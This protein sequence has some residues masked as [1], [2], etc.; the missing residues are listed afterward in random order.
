[1]TTYRSGYSTNHVLIGLIENWKHALDNNLFI[2]AVLMDLLKA[3]NRISHDLLIANL[4]AYILDFD[5]VMFL[6][7]YL[8]HRKQGVKIDNVSSF[9]RTILLGVQQGSV[10]VPIL[11]NI[12]INELFLSLTNSDLQNFAND[13]TIAVTGKNLNEL[14]HTLEKE[15][16]SDWFRNNNMIANSDKF[17]AIVMNKRREN[18]VT[19]KLKIY[20]NEIE[21][22]KSVKL[23]DIEIDNQLSKINI[24]QSCVLKLPRN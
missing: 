14:L 2:G 18:K 6:H 21:T 17:Q 22:T 12:F 13:N 23:L 3:F 4:H 5:T 1:M 19:H 8:K 9:F 11:F 15:S 24:Q 16:E 10:L 20:N 7:N